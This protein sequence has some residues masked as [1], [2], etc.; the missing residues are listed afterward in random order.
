MKRIEISMFLKCF[1]LFNLIIFGY[2]LFQSVLA[3]IL[4]SFTLYITPRAFTL[5]DLVHEQ[6]ESPPVMLRKIKT[7]AELSLKPKNCDR[8]IVPN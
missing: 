4:K 8:W 3:G 5:S 2:L 1:S 6:T 7:N